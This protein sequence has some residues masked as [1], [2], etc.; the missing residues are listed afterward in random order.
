MKINYNHLQEMKK[1]GTLEDLRKYG[2]SMSV[3]KSKTI[4]KNVKTFMSFQQKGKTP[5]THVIGKN[6]NIEIPF[7]NTLLKM[8]KDGV[9]F[10][11]VH[12]HGRGQNEGRL[13]TIG[14]DY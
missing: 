1:I 2:I 7:R 6:L 13:L 3:F 12:L 4:K 5:Q 9:E 11:V 8:V 10:L 14:L